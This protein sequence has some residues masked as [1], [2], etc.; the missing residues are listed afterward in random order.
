MT[1]LVANPPRTAPRMAPLGAAILSLGCVT[2]ACFD[3]FVTTSDR[4]LTYT[5][6][7]LY[8]LNMY[9]ILIGLFMLVTGL[10]AW[11]GGRGKIGATITTVGLAAAAVDGIATIVTRNDQALGPL[12]LLGTFVSIIGL[13]I[14]AIASI[15]ARILPW[16]TTAALAATWIIG[17]LV[18][19]GGP[20]GFKGSALLLA[21]AGI[22]AAVTSTRPT[23]AA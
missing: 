11:Q 10:R 22:A 8:T 14:F 20:L 7:Y 3:F 17:G 2:L 9:P 4:K 15:R 12:Y 13:T 16:W 1:T 21:I 6:D 23:R 19:D 18:G 5:A